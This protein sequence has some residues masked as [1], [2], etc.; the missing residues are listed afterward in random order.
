[1]TIESEMQNVIVEED[2]LAALRAGRPPMSED[3][4]NL[5]QQKLAG[6]DLSGLNLANA[7]LTGAD[8]SGA[9]LAG[10]NLI[11]A[12]LTD[13]RLFAANLQG[14]ILSN[15]ILHN[16]E[17]SGSDLT[18]AALDC[19]T[20]TRAGFGMACLKNA[21]LERACLDE[22]TLSE[23]DL[24]GA[25]LTNAS[26][27][28]V[29][30]RNAV[31]RNTDFNSAIMTDVHLSKSDVKGASFRNA[32]LRGGRMRMVRGYL[33][34][35]WIGVEIHDISFAGSLMLRR[36][37]MD[38]NYIMEY[39]Q[40]SRLA[41]FMYYPWLITS[42]CGRSL[43]R[44]CGMIFLLAMT[45]AMIYQKVGIDYGEYETAFSPLYFSV[46]TITTLG[47]GDVL[48]STVAGQMVAISEVILGYLMLGGLL[49]IFSNKIARRAE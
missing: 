36:F 37:I 29:R 45:Y 48:P 20:A 22:A 44:W 2:V 47:Y 32:D 9:N 41:G 42:D 16:T 19:V 24:S 5:K 23:A 10:V 14:A 26:L 46:V 28:S 21:R 27:K 30:L 35:D 1:M 13:A 3:R 40:S 43:V 49:A 38:Q 39:R 18:D 34:A 8:L 31:L 11:G 15:A 25:N 4:I 12:D 17:L 6:C 7:D 33:S